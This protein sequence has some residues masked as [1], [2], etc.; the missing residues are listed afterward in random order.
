[1]FVAIRKHW[2][3]LDKNLTFLIAMSIFQERSAWPNRALSLLPMSNRQ[4]IMLSGE[5]L[6]NPALIRARYN[7]ARAQMDLVIEEVSAKVQ[8][9]VEANI[10]A[11]KARAEEL[12]RISESVVSL[13]ELDIEQVG[14]AP[15]FFT[16]CDSLRSLAAV[17]E[18]FEPVF[19]AFISEHGT[20]L[21]AE[22]QKTINTFL[23]WT[24]VQ[25]DRIG[26]MCEQR[27]LEYATGLKDAET[28]NGDLL[29]DLA[30]LRLLS[31]PCDADS[32]T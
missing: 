22:A 7:L 19:N 14:D 3:S 18:N 2:R 31:W 6:Q 27:A 32:A 8:Q 26:P 11:A 13:M 16:I 1:M 25:H 28:E 4:P 20:W 5:D 17:A 23:V 12:R 24:R 21:E 10:N 9:R 30:Q 29:G 15:S